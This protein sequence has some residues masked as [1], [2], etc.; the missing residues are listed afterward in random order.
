MTYPPNQPESVSSQ[1]LALHTCPFGDLLS[2]PFEQDLGTTDINA[3]GVE[4]LE[5]R[6][7]DRPLAFD[8]RSLYL[9]LHGQDP[10]ASIDVYN[11]YDIWLV[12]HSLSAIK[13]DGNASVRRLG[14]VTELVDPQ[15][16]Y[17]IDL[18]P[19]TRFIRR[20]AARAEVGFDLSADGRGEIVTKWPETDGLGIGAGVNS[21]AGFK[22]KL[23]LLAGMSF[24][25]LS[26]DVQAVGTG[27]SRCEWCFQATDEP[28]LG[29]QTMLQ[30]LLVYKGT[31][32]LAFRIRAYAHISTGWLRF[33]VAYETDWIDADCTLGTYRSLAKTQADDQPAANRATSERSTNGNSD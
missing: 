8:L 30:T 24:S 9:Q 4:G 14:F 13:R 3:V 21:C 22:G 28:L 1:A 12:R 29:D 11:P 16:A 5:V 20:L 2:S 6:V 23:E 10:A 18:L 17:V 15:A 32:R 26:A 7:G 31:R 33:P 25:V 27:S 19:Q